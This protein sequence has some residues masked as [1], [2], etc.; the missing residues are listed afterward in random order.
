MSTTH[1]Q[2]DEHSCKKSGCIP[3]DKRPKNWTPSLG[4]VKRTKGV[5]RQERRVARQQLASK[6]NVE[7][8]Q[9]G[10]EWMAP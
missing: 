8:Y 10:R 9:N 5:K 1:D 4:P 6:R 3:W 2:S 7:F